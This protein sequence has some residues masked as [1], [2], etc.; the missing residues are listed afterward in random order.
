MN[1]TTE[2]EMVGWHHQRDEGEFEYAPGDGDGQGR[3]ACYCP[4]VTKSWTQLSD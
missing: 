1:G 2:N 3:L 4:W